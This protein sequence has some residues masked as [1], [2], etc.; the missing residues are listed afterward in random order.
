MQ[1][2]HAGIRRFSTTSLYLNNL[3]FN[4]ISALGDTPAYNL[5]CQH[6]AILFRLGI[7]GSKELLT[8]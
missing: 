8:L 6:F 4:Q 5:V 2:Y 7:G 1:F 3:S